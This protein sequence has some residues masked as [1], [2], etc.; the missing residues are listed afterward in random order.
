MLCEKISILEK[1]ISDEETLGVL[2][3][4]N[5][6]K[7]ELFIIKK[8]NIKDDVMIENYLYNNIL[9][10]ISIFSERTLEEWLWAGQ[11]QEIIEW[12]LTG[13]IEYEKNSFLQQY[14]HRLQIFPDH[15]REIRMGFEFSKLIHCYNEGKYFFEVFDYLDSYKYVIQ[16]LHHLG[17]LSV[18]QQGIHPEITVWNQVKRLEPE[19]YKL[20]R[21]LTES[22]ETIDKRL[23][24]L[25]LAGDYLINSQTKT[26]SKHVLSIIKESLCGLTYNELSTKREVSIYGSELQALLG[27]LIEKGL[28]EQAEGE[29]GIVRY[30]YK[31]V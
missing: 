27:Y 21:E 19:V 30:L 7:L 5:R 29:D 8:S 22:R 28:L 26:S 14:R 9:S 12:I 23:E 2:S 6:R 18:V 15:D 13:N 3:Q 4:N 16:A 10:T 1:H 25:F 31:E 20:Y 24:L 17:R 11:K